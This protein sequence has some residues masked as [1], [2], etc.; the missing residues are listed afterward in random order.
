MRTSTPRWRSANSP[1]RSRS[2]RPAP[3]IDVQSIEQSAA[4]DRDIYES[5]P[6]ARQYDNLA[7]L[8]PAMNIAGGSPRRACRRIRPASRARAATACPFT[9]RSRTTRRST[10][11]GWTSAA[12]RSTA[13][14]TSPPFDTGIA[15]F[16][17][18]YS[19]NSA[20]VETGGVRLN[21]IPKEGSNTF[22]GSM[23]LDGTHSAWLANNVDDELL[24]RGITGGRDGGTAL[25]QGVDDRTS[26]RWPDRRRSAVVLRH[27]FL[28]PRI[29]LP[30]QLFRQH[31]HQLPGVCSP[32]ST[33]T[34]SPGRTSPRAAC[35]SRGRRRRRTR[36]RRSPA[37]PATAGTSCRRCPAPTST[38][39]TSPP[40][41]AAR[42][43]RG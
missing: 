28:P 25:D 40:R 10:S 22:S 18:D 32:T 21:M 12:R 35:A 1:R 19:G 13:P 30:R 33:G 41:P 14:R 39:S 17:Y 16:V 4:I 31:R 15:E 7:L 2:P 24:G 34:C 43:R 42:T 23:R 27:L 26:H 20:E 5:L 11:T 38:R 3:V 36:S 8:I 29:D 6:T 37:C 9:A